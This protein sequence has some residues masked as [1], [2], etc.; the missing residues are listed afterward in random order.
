MIRFI[1]FLRFVKLERPYVVYRVRG[2]R[3]L[4]LIGFRDPSGFQWY[5]S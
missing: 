1:W 3:G 4:G 5:R 2:S